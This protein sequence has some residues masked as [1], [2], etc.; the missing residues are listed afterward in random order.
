MSQTTT[1]QTTISVPAGSSG[2]DQIAQL[3]TGPT[4]PS[5]QPGVFKRM[6]ATAAGV[7]GTAGSVL[8]PGLGALGGLGGV[9]GGA[10]NSLLDQG[11]AYGPTAEQYLA[12]AKQM[13]AQSEAF[14]AVTNVMKSKHSSTMNVIQNMGS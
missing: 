12:V 3:G 13:K 14:E 9:G 10:L 5:T 11:S 6:L 7:A 4:Q 8:L 2:V 1:S